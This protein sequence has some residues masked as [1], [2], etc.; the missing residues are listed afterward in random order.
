MEVPRIAFND[1]LAE[2]ADRIRRERR[3]EAYRDAHGRDIE[4]EQQR[5]AADYFA[6]ADE[7]PSA[8]DVEAL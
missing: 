2:A 3:I 8:Y 6:A 1:P 5:L 7:H 4:R